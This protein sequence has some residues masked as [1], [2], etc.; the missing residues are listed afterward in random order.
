MIDVVPIS[1]EQK[2]FVGGLPIAEILSSQGI[3]FSKLM[4]LAPKGLRGLYFDGDKPIAFLD[5]PPKPSELIG[6]VIDPAIKAGKFPSGSLKAE[7][8]IYQPFSIEGIGDVKTCIVTDFASR[9]VAK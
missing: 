2:V 9:L 1:V 3:D 7:A 6:E 5:F 4:T 8:A